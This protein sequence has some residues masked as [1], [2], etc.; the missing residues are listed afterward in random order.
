LLA[1]EASQ[2]GLEEVA[3]LPAT[4]AAAARRPCRGASV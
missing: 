3:V 2:V 1:V 4:P